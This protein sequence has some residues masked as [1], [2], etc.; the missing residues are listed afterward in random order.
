MDTND[1]GQSAMIH[2]GANTNHF[3]GNKKPNEGGITK[4]R[5]TETTKE[6]KH[7][8]QH[9]DLVFYQKS[10]KSTIRTNSWI[11]WKNYNKWIPT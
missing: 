3:H 8:P 2:S 5:D 7:A 6:E 1:Y 4:K 10:E 9:E 11:W